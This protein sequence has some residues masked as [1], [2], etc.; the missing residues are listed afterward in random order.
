MD[1]TLVRK[2]LFFSLQASGDVRKK[3]VALKYHVVH[4]WFVCPKP[5]PPTTVGESYVAFLLNELMT[6]RTKTSSGITHSLNGTT[7]LAGF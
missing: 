7:Y 6:A 5:A 2:C 3:I 4:H 1:G